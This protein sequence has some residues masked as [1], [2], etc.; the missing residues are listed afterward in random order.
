MRLIL[1]FAA[2][3]V[4]PVSATARECRVDFVVDA[5]GRGAPTRASLNCL[6][7]EIDDLK[8]E[9]ARLRERLA[10]QEAALEAALAEIPGAFQNDNGRLSFDEGRRLAEASFLLSA[11][12]SDGASALALNQDVIETLCSRGGGCAITLFLRAEGLRAADPAPAAGIGPCAFHYNPRNG[13]WAASACGE[14]AAARGVDGDGSPRGAGGGEI[15]AIAGG[16][17]LLAD[18][19]PRLSVGPDAELLGRDHALGF[20]LVAAPALR[21]PSERFRCEL[22]IE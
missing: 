14:G 17:C 21:E 3:L 5:F 19:D 2:F 10:A 12:Q 13:V 8:R 15:A 4:F 6:I 16:A 9:Q 22:R 18:S 1:L 7:D 20:F 11:R